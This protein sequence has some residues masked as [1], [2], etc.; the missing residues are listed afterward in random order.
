MFANSFFGASF[1]FTYIKAFKHWT[2]NYVNNSNRVTWACVLNSQMEIF[3]S[4]E[5]IIKKK[6]TNKTIIVIDTL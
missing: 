1:A 5:I 3:E 2:K 6:F 4:Y